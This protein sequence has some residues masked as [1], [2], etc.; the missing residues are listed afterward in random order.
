MLSFEQILQRIE[1][2]IS[3]LQYIRE[4]QSLYDPINYILSLGG[5]RIRPALTLIACNMY[6]E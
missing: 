5:K 3:K 6:S 1:S 4:P 2:E